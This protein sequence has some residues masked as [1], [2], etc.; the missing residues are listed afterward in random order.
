[1]SDPT[2]IRQQQ[3]ASAAQAGLRLGER[4]RHLRVAAGMTQTDLAGNRFSKEYVSQIERGKT[5]PTRETIDW[6]AERLGVDSGFLANG[7]SADERGR[8][9]AAL[10]RAEALLEARRNEEALEEFERVR[11]A[12]L[13]TGMPELESRALSGEATVRMRAGDVREAIALLERA[14][15]LSEGT[16]FS[17]I[18]RADVLFRLGVARYKLNSIQTSIGLFDEALKVAE[19]SEIPS[20]QL[21]SNILAWR[22]RCY[23]RRRDLEAARE[24]VERA[25][26]LA[27]GLNDKRTAADVYFQASIIA[28][29]E[30]HWVLARSYAERAKAVYEELSD[31]SNLGRLLNN[32]GGIN[33]LLGHPEEAVDFLKD[34]VGIAL[35]VGNDAEAAH[36]VNGIAQV[37]LRTGDSTRA[38]EQARYALELLGDRVDET[39]EIGNA[40]LV[41]GRALLEQGRLDEADEALQA[42]ERAYDQLSSGS[43]RASAWVA[44]GDL[45]ARRGDDRAAARLYRQAADALQDVRF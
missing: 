44:Q 41:L 5:R 36:A 10:A 19:R 13:A 23:R 16:S 21:R 15:V 35:E 29:R 4:L 14:R 11:P 26:E 7:V 37:H 20:D 27:E 30:G 42:G 3:R 6:I 32:L 12:V 43:H 39:A 40:Q 1:M 8:V 25:L 38:E 18:E 24:D 34:A 31:R 2:A 9:D 33:F 28:D 17:D 22:S 45:A